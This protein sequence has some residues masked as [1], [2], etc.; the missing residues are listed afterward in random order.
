[1]DCL[2]PRVLT[3]IHPSTESH[4][5]PQKLVLPILPAFSTEFCLFAP[6]SPLF[7]SFFHSRLLYRF[8]LKVSFRRRLQLSEKEGEDK[9]KT[10]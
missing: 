2:H 5:P 10:F 1:M 9:F 7:L 8:C 6:I 3:P 4:I